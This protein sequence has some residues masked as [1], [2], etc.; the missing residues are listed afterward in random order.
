MT[1]NEAALPALKTDLYVVAIYEAT[2][3]LLAVHGP[4]PDASAARTAAAQKQDRD[5]AEVYPLWHA[6]H[7]GRD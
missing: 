1:Q 3:S 5:R 4:Y 7:V 2:G 6:D